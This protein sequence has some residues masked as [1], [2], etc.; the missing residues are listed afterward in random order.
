MKEILDELFVFNTEEDAQS[1]LYEMYEIF[2]EQGFLSVAE[3]KKLIGATMKPE[4]IR[5]GWH[6]P[7]KFRIGWTV[8]SD[9][10]MVLARIKFP[11]IEGLNINEIR[12]LG[13]FSP[14]NDIASSKIARARGPL[15]QFLTEGSLQ[16]TTGSNLVKIERVDAENFKM[17]AER[18]NALLEELDGNS[19]KTLAEKNARYSKNGDSLHNFRSGAEIAGGTPAQAC[20]G[21]MTKHLVA[22]RDMV[23]RNDFSNR[24]DFLEKCQDT[25]NYIRFLWCIGNEE[26]NMNNEKESK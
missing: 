26:Q 7:K 16:N 5:T 22:L 1:V 13:G 2:D 3:A 12:K 4:D 19:V 17:D 18:F 6:D 10:L 25:I 24:E 21:Y 23:E 14:I 8:S 9:G 15:F 20:W 11:D